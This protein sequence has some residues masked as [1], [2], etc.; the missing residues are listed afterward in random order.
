ME[1]AEK[2]QRLWERESARKAF[3][4]AAGITPPLWIVAFGWTGAGA[5]ALFLMAYTAVAWDLSRRGVRLPILWHILRMTLR[6]GETAPVSALEFLAAIVLLGLLFPLPYFL[7]AIALLGVGDGAAALVGMRWGR[8]KL[9]WNPDKSWEG[10]AAGVAFGVPAFVGFG[11]IGGFLQR[12]GWAHV[13][14]LQG[15][16]PSWP[17]VAL[18]LGGF[19]LL[20][21]AA[22]GWVAAGWGPRAANAPFKAVLAAFSVALAPALAWTLAAPI[23]LSGPILPTQGGHG[24]G[25]QAALLVVPVVAML[26]ESVA[27]RHDNLLVPTTACVLA[28]L[29]VALG[30]L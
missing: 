29:V 10:L 15:L 12:D 13:S 8:H 26:A 1:R 17:A 20:H 4:I 24:P 30:N 6:K 16:H 11:V 2:S 7:G 14:S 5:I 28:Y 23:F 25:T 9:P 22:R 21:V 3:H 19:P 27:R 18:F